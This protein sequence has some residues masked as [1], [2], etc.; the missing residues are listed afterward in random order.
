MSALTRLIVFLALELFWARRIAS[1]R[2]RLFAALSVVLAVMNLAAHCIK[3]NIPGPWILPAEDQHFYRAFYAACVTG[4]YLFGIVAVLAT[5]AFG[6]RWLWRRF[7]PE[8]VPVDPAGHDDPPVSRRSVLTAG[9]AGS[10]ALAG[11][12]TAASARVRPDEIVIERWK[13]PLNARH[14]HA[15]GFRIVQITDPHVGPMFDSAAWSRALD[16]GVNERPSL[17]ALTGDFID[18][19]NEKWLEPFIQ[20]LSKLPA[21]VPSIAVTGNH[22]HYWGADRLQQSVEARTPVRFLRNS[23]SRLFEESHGIEI[24]GID[25]PVS[26]RPGLAPAKGGM[27]DGSWLIPDRK[28]FRLLLAHRPWVVRSGEVQRAFNL[29]LAGHTH[30]GMVTLNVPFFPELRLFRPLYD[31]GWYAPDWRLDE[32]GWLFVGRGVGYAGPRLRFNCPPEVAVIEFSR[33]VLFPVR[34]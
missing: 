33:D 9:A 8:A 11:L 4:H 23:V 20:P 16:L 26:Q 25:D 34:M 19:V 17:L 29:T 7:L 13:F 10:F 15:H 5:L 32:S 6:V 14:E 3:R 12:G 18:R 30:G 21:E 1:G 31:R 2:R 24:T 28:R 27:P 22:D